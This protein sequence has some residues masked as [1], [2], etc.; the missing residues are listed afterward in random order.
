MSVEEVVTCSDRIN[1]CGAGCAQSCSNI[2]NYLYHKDENNV[3]ICCGNGPVNCRK[4]A[5]AFF[6]IWTG[7]YFFSGH[8]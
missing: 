5:F 2:S 8:Y 6:M 7:M 1:N 3:T 4:I